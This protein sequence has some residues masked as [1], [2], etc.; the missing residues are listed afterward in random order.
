[1]GKL[2]I[3]AGEFADRVELGAVNQI[4]R[5]HKP[6]FHEHARAHGRRPAAEYLPLRQYYHRHSRG[7]FWAA[8]LLV[9]F[10]NHPAFR[11]PLGWLMP[12]KISFLKITET[13]RQ[14]EAYQDMTIT[15]EGLVPIEYLVKTVGIC[16]EL[17]DAYPIWLCPAKLT[18]TDPPGLAN[19]TSESGD[20]RMYVDVGVFFSVP[21]PVRRGEPWSARH[22]IRR[23]E[24]WLR[25][26]EGF[27]STYAASD[28]TRSAS[29][30]ALRPIALTEYSIQQ[31]RTLRPYRQAQG[32]RG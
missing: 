3:I 16:H 27:P 24:A 29:A 15:Q 30:R 11:W 8:A 12:P 19:L 26:H 14:R 6:W 2:E 10:G 5:W 31:F 1:M 23:F 17:F 20:A 13:D 32:S 9:P 18:R 4:G 28:M 25:E 7:I 21:G 22:A